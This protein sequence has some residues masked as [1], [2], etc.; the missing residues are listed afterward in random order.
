MTQ[1]LDAEPLVT[2]EWLSERATDPN[3]RAIEVDV[4]PAA[5]NAG[6][7]AG[8]QLWNV[9][10]DLLQPDY[11]IIERDAFAQLLGR[12]GITPDMQV[13]VYGYAA[14]MAFWMMVHYG[15]NRVSLLSGSRTRWNSSSQRPATCVRR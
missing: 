13:V 11:R 10:S 14:A 12:S 7:I 15:H 9:Y 6:H 8:A 3:V 1:V 4:S 5:Y 2:T